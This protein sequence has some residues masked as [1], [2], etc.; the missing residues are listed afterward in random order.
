[1]IKLLRSSCIV[2]AML[3]L[4]STLAI[5]AQ[6]QNSTITVTG[7]ILDDAG[8]PLE[9]VTISIKNQTGNAIS[10]ADGSYSIVVGP[11]ATLVFTAVGFASQEV[12][13]NNKTSIS[14][15]LVPSSSKLDDVVVIGY[16]TQKKRNVTGAIAS[17]DA[18][19]LDER[20]IVRVDQALIGQMA[21]VIVKQTTGALGK[22]LS[23]QVRGTG[24]IS[25]GNEPLYVLD[26]FPLDNATPN[27]SGN[28]AN[29]NPLDNM[30]PNDIESVQV[31]KDAS[32]AAIYGSR[33]A[34]GV[35]LI[36]TKRGK[37]GKPKLT[38]NSY[39]GYTERTRKLDMLNAE[40]WIDR[41]TE[42]INAQWVASGTGRTA[43]QTTA[44]RRTILG[45][46]AG[47]YNTSFMLDDRWAQPGHPGLRFIDWQDETFRKG[48]LHNQQL[49]ASGGNEFVKYYVSGNYSHQDGMVIGSDYT[50]YSARANVEVTASKKIKLGLN[51]SPTFSI[52]NDP[53]IE[54]KDN[55][56]HQLVSMTPVQ[57][58]TMGLYNN[59]GKNGQYIWSVSPNSPLAK[60]E[61]LMGQTRRYRTLASMYGEYQPIKG[62]A[63]KTT[64]NFDNTDNVAQGYAPYAVGGTVV[65]R[66]DNVT[67]LTLISGS[68][69]TYRKL[70]FVN[71]NTA[72]YST[73]IAS[74]HDLN[75]LAG[76]AYNSNKLDV[77]NMSSN[78]GYNNAIVRTLSAAKAITGTST[79][80]KSTMV[81][82]FGRLQYA[83]DGKY[84]VSA[85]WRRDG[86]S[87][88]GS[89]N[90]F[91][92]FPSASLGWRVSDEKFMKNLR[93]IND[94][95]VRA[96]IGL[97][98]SNNI[99]DYATNPGLGTYSYTLNGVSV[100][101]NMP[102]GVAN[103][104]LGWEKSRTINIGFDATVLK[105]R[106]TVSF[107][108]YDK[109]NK[110]LLLNVPVVAATG[111]NSVLS[112][113]G[114]VSNK[115]VELEIN[116]RNLI[117]KF[118]WSTAFNISHNSN[119]V[120]SLPGGQDQILI[121]SSFDI[122]HSILKVGEAMNSIYVVKMIGIL[123]QDDINKG[124]AR[125]GNEAVGDPKYF[126]ANG[127][128]TIDANDR[129][130]VGQPT[131][132]YTWSLTNNF[133]YKG[134]DLSIQVQGQNG[135]SIYSLLGRALGRTGQGFT[136]NALG[137]YRN[138][139][140][141]EANPGD[142][143][144]SKAYS[145]FGRIKNTDWLYSSDYYRIRNITLGYDLGAKIKGKLV[146]GARLYLTLENFFGKDKYYGGT[147]PEA[148][149]TNLSG[150]DTYPEAGDYGGL[151]IPK[152]LVFGVNF[153][154]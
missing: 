113:A 93:F 68:Y 13:V 10:K 124:V 127:D 27:G 103:P 74:K 116:S 59:A 53:G 64:V 8:K 106:I 115:G 66:A 51:I 126:D 19:N 150:S 94:L 76:I 88:F 39:V 101:G 70:T 102:A 14:I 9:A 146:Q 15:N 85:S 28:Y 80:V 86:S 42:I 142:G 58:D 117:G 140:R 45:L 26:G 48:I 99:T 18:K 47:T 23:I 60:L 151:P 32:A 82:Y 125:N 24:S 57:E 121:P 55:I 71:E 135:G 147:N 149:N 29:G 35:V 20:P 38:L 91:G 16:G 90:Q 123:T 118:Q 65:T 22:G 100:T 83:Y 134:F 46:A 3:L 153:T 6:S 89:N 145:T 87:R 1:M 122:Q 41:A 107:D 119:K 131:P 144:I 72:T 5:N 63:L 37:S 95:K 108:Y 75:I 40:E 11:N 77:G 73:I 52:I 62:L 105:N 139:W 7:K 98:G 120:M 130:I 92:T 49:S 36:T 141:S 21:G 84:L 154:F 54:G 112:N 69:N 43:T 12:E 96:S 133:R 128:G 2:F 138:R 67:K 114:S 25:A 136:D 31:L 137:L 44:E 30:N 129:V 152:S 4:T 34:N 143:V 56:Y 50:L 148:S 33:A 81:S 61:N 111:F 79:E 132:K 110:D 104:D 78:G 17:Y 109:F 97:S